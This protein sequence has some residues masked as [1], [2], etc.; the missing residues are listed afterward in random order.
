ML[1]H[2][3]NDYLSLDEVVSRLEQVFGFVN[4]ET[5]GA[6]VGADANG[7]QRCYLTIADSQDHGLAYL[8]SQFEP[9]Q[10]LFFG[11]VS[12]EHEDAAAPLVERVA[13]ALDYELEEL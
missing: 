9:D 13:K 11:F 4:A 12:G 6:A 2:A 5:R 8:L 7:N 10:P 1:E 3:Y